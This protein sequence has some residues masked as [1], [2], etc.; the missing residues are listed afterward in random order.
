MAPCQ[1]PLCPHPKSPEVVSY[2]EEGGGRGS[3]VPLTWGMEHD[4]D[5]GVLLHKL[6]KVFIGQVINGA[7]LI[8]PGSLGDLG[9][10]RLWTGRPKTGRAQRKPWGLNS[11]YKI[12]PPGHK[13]PT[14]RPFIHWKLDLK[15]ESWTERGCPAHRHL[16][17]KVAE[18]YLADTSA[19]GG[20]LLQ[21]SKTAQEISLVPATGG[22][23]SLFKACK[24]SSKDKEQWCRMP[25]GEA[26]CPALCHPLAQRKK[27]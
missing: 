1:F 15:E 26:G 27:V 20:C 18:R 12:Q 17:L 2:S 22:L 10:W 13:A 14:P 6:V 8:C 19:H 3:G 5:R 24:P 7:A 23:A 21:L 16:P 25:S 4:E 11:P 9:L